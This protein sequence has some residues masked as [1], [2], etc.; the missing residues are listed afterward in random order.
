MSD[1][2]LLNK[3]K[4]FDKEWCYQYQRRLDTLAED[5]ER[6]GW[7]DDFIASIGL[8][9]F[10]FKLIET[11]EGKEEAIKF[12]QRYEWLGTIGSYPTH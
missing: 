10:E 7:D 1:I 2:S 3:I 9:D 5:K 11:K 6:L 4:E 12:I 8:D